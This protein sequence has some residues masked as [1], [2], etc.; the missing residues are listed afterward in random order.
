MQLE[1]KNSMDA[2]QVSEIERDPGD[3]GGNWIQGLN[4][5]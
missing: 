2:Q 4:G 5:L 3:T 1:G